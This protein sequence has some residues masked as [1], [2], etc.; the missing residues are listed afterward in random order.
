MKY[1]KVSGDEHRDWYQRLW[2][3]AQHSIPSC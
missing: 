2:N 1:R 3:P